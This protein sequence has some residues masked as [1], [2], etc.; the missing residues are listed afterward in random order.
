MLTPPAVFIL[1]AFLIIYWLTRD[2]IV[3]NNLLLI[4]F[5]LLLISWVNIWQALLLVFFLPL[6][7]F[8]ITKIFPLNKWRVPGLY[9]GI[10]TNLCIWLSSRYLMGDY[11]SS[12]VS[13]VQIGASFYILRKLSFLIAAF[14]DPNF[15]E[16]SLL[17]YGLYVTF[18]PQILSGPI[19]RPKSFLKQ[20]S[21]TRK[22]SNVDWYDCFHLIM[23]GMFKKIAIADNVRVVVDR[24]FQLNQ[25][26]MIIVY[27]GTILFALQ[28]FCDFSGYTD[29]SRGVAGL[30][31]FKTQENFDNPLLA[32]TPQDFWSRWHISL[33]QWLQTHIFYPIRRYF[34]RKSSF[35][36]WVN[37]YLAIMVTMMLSGY[38]H[39]SSLKFLLWGFYHGI[40]LY[41]F[42]IVGA[43]QW[44]RKKQKKWHFGIWF[45]T[46]HVILIGWLIF[47]SHDLGW[48]MNTIYQGIR[49]PTREEWVVTVSII[50]QLLIFSFP[51]VLHYLI[52][53]NEL[54]ARV[55]NPIFMAVLAIVLI[56]FNFSGFQTFIYAGF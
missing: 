18:F 27:I 55:G 4:T 49:S 42:R 2:H 38:W 9:L 26:N 19:E 21:R 35:P 52:N 23:L 24:I 15:E 32:Q 50:S 46:S 51:L 14:Q 30:M 25:A 16:H 36:D 45:V 22:I 47:R 31:G 7:Y 12:M 54:V 17:E 40:F 3:L 13:T 29:I 48:L 34:Q 28:I 39:G 5:G 6:D 53:R 33:T 44:V 10:L 11:G 8:L 56:I 41:L 43:Q 37:V 20:I 1:V